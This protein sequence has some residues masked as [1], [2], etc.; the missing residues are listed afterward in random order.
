MTN[1]STIRTD[2]LTGLLDTGWV[3]MEVRTDGAA[4]LMYMGEPFETEEE[5]RADGLR[6]IGCA[7]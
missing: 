6:A 1:I 7:A 2:Y 5:A 4:G 3:W